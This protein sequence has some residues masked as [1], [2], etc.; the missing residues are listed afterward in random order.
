MLQTYIYLKFGVHVFHF[1]V[2]LRS[3][4][5]IICHIH[6]GL[7]LGPPWKPKSMVAQVPSVK[8]QSSVS[9]WCPQVLCL[10][11]VETI[12]ME[13]VTTEGQL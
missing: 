10:R 7:V 8:K 3:Q 12:P 1:I 11:L 6:W 9:P 2:G 5:T 4:N 13:P